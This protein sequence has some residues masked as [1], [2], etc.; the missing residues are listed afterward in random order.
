MFRA[1][2]Y[3]ALP[4]RMTEVSISIVVLL[5]ICIFAPIARSISRAVVTSLIGGRFSITHRPSTRIVAKRMGSAAFFI[6]PTVMLPDRGLPPLTTKQSINISPYMYI[7]SKLKSH[8]FSIIGYQPAR[9]K[10]RAKRRRS[11]VLTISIYARTSIAVLRFT[12]N[13]EGTRAL[14]AGKVSCC[15]RFAAFLFTLLT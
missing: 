14:F 6:P 13:C 4:Q 8:T 12:G 5:S 3:G 2:S 9:K 7:K 10:S 15:L 11:K 1:S